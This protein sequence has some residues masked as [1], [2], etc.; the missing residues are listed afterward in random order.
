MTSKGNSLIVRVNADLVIDAGWWEE[1]RTGSGKVERHVHPPRQTMYEQLLA[2]LQSIRSSE[3]H[4]FQP[5]DDEAV[6]LLQVCIRWGTYLAVLADHNKPIW[7][8]PAL[9]EVSLISD[10]EMARINIE[11]SAAL[12]QWIEIMRTDRQLYLSLVEAACTLPRA[13]KTLHQPSR[14]YR[15]PLQALAD[16]R[17]VGPDSNMGKALQETAQNELGKKLH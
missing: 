6:A 17:L 5:L 11:A 1:V 9:Q 7:S 4:W 13:F 14:D 2:Y 12:E 10:S 8:I 16:V 3:K 15:A